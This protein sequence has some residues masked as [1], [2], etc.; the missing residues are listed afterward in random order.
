MRYMGFFKNSYLIVLCAVCSACNHE[1]P[2]PGMDFEFHKIGLDGLKVYELVILHEHLYAATNNGVFSKHINTE[3]DFVHL[4]LEGRNVVDFIVFSDQHMIATTANRGP[5]ADDYALL[6]TTNGG[7][8]WDELDIF[9]EDGFEEPVHSLSVHP[10][11]ANV[12]FA[13][14][15][16]SVATSSDYG[17]HWELLWGE[18]GAFASGTSVAEI[19]PAKQTD[20]W[21][22]GQGAIENGYLG[23]LRNETLLNEWFDLVPNPT[24]AVKVAFDRQ[25][26]QTIYVGFEGALIKTTNENTWR[27]V[28]NGSKEGMRFFYGIDISAN[29]Q[30]RVFSGGWLKGEETQPLVLY[31]STNAGETWRSQTLEAE[32][33]GGIYSLKVV[34]ES[35]RERIFV[36]LDKGGVYEIIGTTK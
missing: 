26:K 24:V 15:P 4:G 32:Q 8:S 29:H 21:F 12:I 5:I 18:W 1:V 27:E 19:N 36:G 2:S 30:Q 14:G 7:E 20:L 17:R 34:S 35:D 11:Q 33:S 10:H 3:D 22:G 31:Y 13:T 28:I 25:A 6:E 9:G 23:V 16:R